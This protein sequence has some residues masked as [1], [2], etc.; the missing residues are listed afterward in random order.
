LTKRFDRNV[1]TSGIE[2]RDNI[3]QDQKNFDVD[4]TYLNDK[5]SSDQFSAFVNNEF[6]FN[7]RLQFVAGLRYDSHSEYGSDLSPRASL[8]YQLTEDESAP[9]TLRLSYGEAFRAPNGYELYYNDGGYTTAAALE[10]G[11]ETIETYEISFD[12]YISPGLRASL[13]AYQYRIDDL[14]VLIEEPISELLVFNNVDQVEAYGMEASLEGTLTEN[15]TGRISYSHS[16]VEDGMTG[17]RLVNSP[18]HLGKISLTRPLW[19]D[20]FF[21][22]FEL[23]YISSRDTLADDHTGSSMP[24][25]LTLLGQNILPGLDIT[26]RFHNIFDDKVLYVVS[27]EHEQDML[28]GM[29]RTFHVGLSYNF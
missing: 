4:E 15:L 21:G 5:R 27:V 19:D 16:N 29:G 26:V 18:E 22:A 9:S 11:S 2:Y 13:S 12:H 17:K 10:L 23:Q 28:S 24:I 20:Q 1:L 8:I 3:Q 14:I 7:D 6:S 25:N